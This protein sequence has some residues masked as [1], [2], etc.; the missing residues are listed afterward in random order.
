MKINEL[1]KL[2]S[3]NRKKYIVTNG[4]TINN[5]QKCIQILQQQFI[6]KMKYRI[7]WIMHLNYII[8]SMYTTST[9]CFGLYTVGI[10]SNK[11]PKMVN[12]IYEEWDCILFCDF[13][14]S[15]R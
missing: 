15:L 12:D 6:F 11:L 9:I 4:K 3:K 2:L 14:K 8:M 13:T 7:I 1:A 5:M 10:F